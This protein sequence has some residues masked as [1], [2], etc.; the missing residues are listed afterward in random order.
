MAPWNVPAGQ[1]STAPSGGAATVP[2]RLKEY[3]P[4]VGG[5]RARKGDLIDLKAQIDVLAMDPLVATT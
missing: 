1:L 4:A 5:R 2:I 3:R